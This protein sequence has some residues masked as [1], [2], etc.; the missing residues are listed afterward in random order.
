MVARVVIVGMTGRVGRLIAPFLPGWVRPAGRGIAAGLDWDLMD[1]PAPLQRLAGDEGVPAALVV[2]AGVTPATA[3]PGARPGAGPGLEAN[4]AMARAA[5]A[6]ARA[7][8]VGRV[9]LASS[10][11]VYGGRAAPWHEGE[12]VA[13]ASAYGRAKLAMEAAAEP[14]RDAGLEVCALRIGNVAGADA[15]LLRAPG[16]VV[17]DRFAGGGGPVRSYVGPASLAR[18]LMALAAA[19]G[20]IPPVLNLAAPGA[21]AM[22]DL[23]CAAGLPW[24]WRPA[25]EGAV[26]RVVMDG[27]ALARLVPMA[28]NEGEAATLI[29]QWRAARGEG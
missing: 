20:A 4:V 6:A 19:R 15:L 1:G 17:L 13:P 22:R 25:A 12:A 11:A 9:L 8:G 26:E 24:T 27:T 28:Q 14:F 21:V 2:L 10:A 5:M 18:V 23:A 16:P 7:A 3:A 29:A